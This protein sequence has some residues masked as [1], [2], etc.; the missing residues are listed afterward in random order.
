MDVTIIGTGNMA[1]AIGRR[2]VAGGHRLT[3]LGKDVEAAEA[4][5]G[6]IG[7]DGSAEAGRSGDPIADEV[8]VLAVYY[9]DAVAAVEQYGD[10]LSGKVLVDITN[11]VNETYDDLVTPP[12]GSAA[13]E[14]ANASGARVVKA[15][16]TTFANTL[17]EGQVAGQ[18]LDVFLAGDDDDAKAKVASLAEDA[19]LRPVDVGPLRR[20]RE[21]EAA[22]LLH[23]S[24]QGTLGT[25]FGS[26]L[27]IL[28]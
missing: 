27:K 28:A 2:V 16:N 14:L 10:G 13:Q 18:P 15:F 20:A 17:N 7:G 6:D 19:G 3:V 4:A 24:V 11:P 9:P 21:L 1:R 22:G 8:V 23:M 5:V 26:A 12:D 25:G